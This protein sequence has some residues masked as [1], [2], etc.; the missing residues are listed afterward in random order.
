MTAGQFPAMR[1]WAWLLAALSLLVVLT[2]VVLRLNAGYLACPDAGN[3]VRGDVLWGWQLPIAAIRVIHRVTASAALVLAIFFAWRCLRL[4]SVRPLAR[5]GVAL[6]LLMLLLAVVGVAGSGPDDVWGRFV[7]ILGGVG[8]LSLSGRLVLATHWPGVVTASRVPPGRILRAGLVVL[9][10]TIVLS[11]LIGA[12][13]AAAMCTSV[14]DCGGTWWPTGDAWAAL[15]PLRVLASTP[16]PGEAPAVALHLLH[17]YAA[18]MAFL[19]LGFIGLRGLGSRATHG[20]SVT[21]LSVLTLT[22]LLGGLTATTGGSVGPVVGHAALAGMLLVSL[23]WF[24]ACG[25]N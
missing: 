24:K 13:F 4:P 8:L 23:H 6:V 19:L 3:C 10:A 22:I 25:R 2:S 11:A 1:K 20:A 14:P 21:V 15:N 7:N 5:D 9:T 17:R 18:G 12:R 16:L